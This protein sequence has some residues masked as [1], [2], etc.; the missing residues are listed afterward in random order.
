MAS[1]KHERDLGVE[2]GK[3]LMSIFRKPKDRK[4]SWTKDIDQAS[5]LLKAANGRQLQP[6]PRASYR[7]VFNYQSSVNLLVY[8]LLSVHAV[9]SDQVR[10]FNRDFGAWAYLDTAYSC[11][12]TSASRA[13]RLF[14]G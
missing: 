3:F 6:P 14:D 9:A 8:F 7:Q 12:P 10:I 13:K 4:S 11:I 2:T 1:L 5:P